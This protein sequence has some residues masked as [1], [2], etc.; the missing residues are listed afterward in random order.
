M[1]AFKNNVDKPTIIPANENNKTGV[2]IAPPKRCTFC[3]TC[4]KIF[5][6]L[7]LLVFSQTS[8]LLWLYSISQKLGFQYNFP[9]YFIC[10]ALIPLHF[11]CTYAQKKIKNA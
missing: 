6:P 5:P 4:F 9:I 3:I 8:L 2:Y 1:D 7:I 11:F 10:A